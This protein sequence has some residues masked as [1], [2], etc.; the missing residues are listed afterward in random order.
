MPLQ[1]ALRLGLK[2][3]RGLHAA[4]E[5]LSPEGEALGLVHRD[6]STQ[7]VLL[8]FDGVAWVYDFGIAEAFGNVS[9]TTTGIL[10]GNAGYLAPEQLR[11]EPV[12]GRTDLFALGVVLYEV[13]AGERL[14]GGAPDTSDG[15][16]AWRKGSPRA[17]GRVR[18]EVR[19]RGPRH[20]TRRSGPARSARIAWRPP[21]IQAPPRRG[22]A[23]VT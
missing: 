22:P 12:D 5:A 14:Y 20:T 2:A 18:G 3:A 19:S 21:P 17:G 1:V 13:L 15:D 11:F 6:V 8:G 7:N 4:H 16:E 23:R 10:K 9:R